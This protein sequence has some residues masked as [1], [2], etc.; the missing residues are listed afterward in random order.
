M[1]ECTSDKGLISVF[2]KVELYI[3]ITIVLILGVFYLAHIV[4]IPLDVARILFLAMLLVVALYLWYIFTAK[5][6]SYR[7][8]RRR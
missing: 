8:A 4:P 1:S 5:I 7:L 3:T 6:L 2:A